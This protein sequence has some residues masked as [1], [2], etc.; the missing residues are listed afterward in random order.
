M[1]DNYYFGGGGVTLITPLSLVLLG[2]ALVLLFLLPRR[3]VIIPLLASALV[4]PLGNQIVVS[5]VHFMTYRLVL[6][7]AWMRIGALLIS[8]EHPFPRFNR[9]DKVFLAWALVSALLYSMLWGEWEAV[10]NRLGFLYSTLGAY[11]LL[12]FLIR[13]PADTRRTIKTLAL[14]M[15]II[16]P[17][18]LWEHW[19]GHNLFA[20]VGGL[21]ALS[22]ARNGRIR[23]Q[24]PFA[25]S[26]VAGTCG[27][28]L[29]PL[30]FS[31]WWSGKDRITAATGIVA[32]TLMTLASASST[33]IATYA[34]GIGAL[35]AWPLRQNMRLVRWCIVIGV[36]ALHLIMR[37]PVWFVISRMSGLLGGSGWH[38]A[39]LIDQFLGHAGEWWLIGTRNS[40]YWGLDMWDAINAYVSAGVNGGLATLC[41]F[42]AILALAYKSVGRARALAETQASQLHVWALGA[43]LFANTVAFF[44]IVYFDQSA[45]VWYGLLSMIS[46]T[47]ASILSAARSAR[48]P[49]ISVSSF[50]AE[51][52]SEPV[53][54]YPIAVRSAPTILDDRR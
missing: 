26:I 41:L 2:L 36:I 27:A 34:A 52:V 50:P 15:A 17:L 45:I 30:F 21:D 38:R 20:W 24:G 22:P 32:S 48:H 51:Y 37:A 5:G 8:R 1:P 42:I 28:M 54:E 49:Q 39:E 6:L 44:G 13:T 46:A 33:P 12:R 4:I 18:M 7:A 47:S 25:H 40:A 35:C 29:V 16:A 31:L 9:L 11:F 3:Y 43:S 53:Y 19:T 10:L 14:I 23:A